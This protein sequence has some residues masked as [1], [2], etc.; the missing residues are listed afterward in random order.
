M[1][2]NLVRLHVKKGRTNMMQFH[3]KNYSETY[4]SNERIMSLRHIV[5]NLATFI[6]VLKVH[7]KF[8]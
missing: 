3:E 1:C 6:K 5:L 4:G 2:D 8:V 7:R